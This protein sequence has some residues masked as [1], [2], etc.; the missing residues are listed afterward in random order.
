M[1]LSS[2]HALV[3]YCTVAPVAR[4]G[5]TAVHPL[6]M[7]K[8]GLDKK[9]GASW[10]VVVGK[11]FSYNVTYEVRSRSPRC[12]SSH[13]RLASTHVPGAKASIP[14]CSA[15]QELPL[16]LCGRHHR[17]AG[18][19]DVRQRHGGGGSSVI[20]P[21]GRGHGAAAG[22]RELGEAGRGSFA[23]ELQYAPSGRLLVRASVFAAGLQGKIATPMREAQLISGSRCKRAPMRAMQCSKRKRHGSQSR[24]AARNQRCRNKEDQG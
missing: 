2:P 15:V 4:A 16:S 6:Q 19:E 7:I 12:C 3:H 18:L 1:G 14:V 20:G 13:H 8:E 17:R 10:H 5:L 11:C 23:G 22:L 21:A 24:H 9:F